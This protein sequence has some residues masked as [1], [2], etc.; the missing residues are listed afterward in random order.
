[1]GLTDEFILPSDVEIRPVRELPREI[2]AQFAHEPGDWAVT[3]H[4]SRAASRIVDDDLASLLLLFRGGNTIARAVAAFSHRSGLRADEVLAQALPG[5]NRFIGLTW[6]ALANSPA[7]NPIG[8]SHPIGSAIAGYQLVD[9]RR[10]LEKSEIY[11]A[12]SRQGELVALKVLPYPPDQQTTLEIRAEISALTTLSGTPSPRLIDHGRDADRYFLATEWC[13][14]LPAPTQAEGLRQTA[15]DGSAQRLRR[16]CLG[17]LDAYSVLHE[18][19][20]V[21]GD[22]HP[23][24]VLADTQGLVRL[25]DFGLSTSPDVPETPLRGGVASYTDPQCASDWLAG[26]RPGWPDPRSEQYSVAA[27]VYLMLTGEHHIRPSAE[28][29]VL[30]RRIAENQLRSFEEVGAAAAPQVESVLARALSTEP[31]QRF[32]SMRAFRDAFSRADFPAQTLRPRK[33]G[34]SQTRRYVDV[35]LAR[36]GTKLAAGNR[37]DQGPHGTV[38]YGSAGIA[39]GLYRIALQREDSELLSE[40]D[41]W[42]AKGIAEI[43]TDD[44]VYHRGLSITEDSVGRSSPYHTHSGIYAVQALVAQSLGDFLTVRR[45][46]ESYLDAATRPTANVDLTLGRSGV[47]LTN[48]LLLDAL[49]GPTPGIEIDDLRRRLRDAGEETMKSIWSELDTAGPI[50]SEDSLAAL[51]VAHGWA[52][53]CH[54]SLLWC[55]ATGADEPAALP[56]RLDQLAGQAAPDGPG[57]RWPI[58]THHRGRWHNFMNSWCNG[59]P[60]YVFLWNAA[61]ERYGQ[62]RFAELADGAARTT[63]ERRDPLGGICCGSTG[64]AYALLNHYRHHRAPVWLERAT[65]LAET[66]RHAPYPTMRDSL[67]K[68]ELGAVVLTAELANPSDARLPFFERD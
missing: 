44:A 18:R 30:L 5:L 29:E 36:L 9:C 50:G 31:A 28:R 53:I 6:L 66:A 48:A 7:V 39:Y 34:S 11:Q 42:A 26:R 55:A 12:M 43:D 20:V 19:G 62:S 10:V 4:N 63:W 35:G 45:S 15:G 8:Q 14:G 25:I 60:G 23:G 40:A 1:M 46:I 67:Y 41:Q 57:L 64:R 32:E 58:Q 24:N 52:G 21:H 3:R 65:A 49:D 61:Y 54:A 47:V 51:G 13:E 37:D 2:R 59:A 56:G 38:F 27:L 33:A 68:G 17:V 22:V 16:L